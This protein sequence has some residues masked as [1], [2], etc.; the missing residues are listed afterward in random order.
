MWRVLQQDTPEDFVLATGETHT[1]RE[2]VEKSFVEL[3]MKI[4]YDQTL[5]FYSS[6]ARLRFFL[7]LRWRGSGEMEEGYDV[8]SGRVVV[9]VDKQYF[10]PAEVECVPSFFPCLGLS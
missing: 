5:S 3:D 2:F 1:V 4:K 10:R 9:K 7:S 6:L 8:E